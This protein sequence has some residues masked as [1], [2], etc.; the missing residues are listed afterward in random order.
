M[1]LTWMKIFLKMKLIFNLVVLIIEQIQD[2]QM[3]S[4][5]VESMRKEALLKPR[6]T[7]DTIHDEGFSVY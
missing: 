1:N 4:F 7:K 5:K 6:E 3:G 2:I